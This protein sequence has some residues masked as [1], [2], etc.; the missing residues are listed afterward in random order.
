LLWF[1]F[2][3]TCAPAA[4]LK[5]APTLP[6]AAD[7]VISAPA[8]RR[9]ALQIAVASSAVA[10]LPARAAAAGAAVD[11]APPA[12]RAAVAVSSSP[13]QELVSG[14]AGGAAQRLAKDIV[15]HPIDTVKVR[16]QASPS[17]R[18]LRRDTFRNLYAG[19]VPPLIVGTPA[20]GLFF[21]VKDAVGAIAMARGLSRDAAEAAAVTAANIPY[22]VL[23]T[24]AELVKIRC[25]AGLV[26]D[27]G[28]SRAAVREIVAS[29]LGVGALWTGFAES[30][31]YAQP[32]DLVKFLAYDRL[33][34]AR[35]QST[36]RAKVTLVEKT[37]LGALAS[38]SAQL[39]TTPLDVIKTRVQTN[40]SKDFVSAAK[41][42][43]EGEGL[44]AFF[45]GVTPRLARSVV[46]GAVQF[47]S[48]ELTKG[49]VNGKQS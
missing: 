42:I 34:R 24:P 5:I 29:E 23:R 27:G 31:A 1:A 17:S 45:S 14:F 32:A 25:Q 12:T 39:V 13:F 49:L 10:L 19:V 11:S 22:W 2:V 43:S 36:G 35:A 33:K 6:R 3:V 30:F 28:G 21:G 7:H 4:A 46:S 48:Y 8:S 20:G 9:R 16:L 15:L 37:L 44:A 47:S 38:A 41:E 26:A 18:V 40:E